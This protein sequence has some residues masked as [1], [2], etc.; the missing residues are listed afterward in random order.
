MAVQIQGEYAGNLKVSLTHGP[1]GTQ[2]STAAPVDNNGDGSSFSPTDLVATA[3]GSCIG[4]I[5]GIYAQR[6]EIDLTG[7]KIRVEKHMNAEPRRI[8]RLPVEVDV[9][10]ALD[11]RHRRAGMR[12]ASCFLNH[13]LQRCFLGD[14][15]CE[16]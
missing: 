11:D 14:V 8:G 2:I 16:Q 9:P 13:I 15:G 6:H 4:T 7:M 3:L 10:V 12:N 1:S 5:M